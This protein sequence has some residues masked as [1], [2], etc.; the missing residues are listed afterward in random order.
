MTSIIRTFQ[1]VGLFA[2]SGY[3]SACTAC[4][5]QYDPKAVRNQLSAESQYANTTHPKLSDAGEL[6]SGDG[7]PVVSVDERYATLCSGCHGAGGGGDG[8]SG[9]AL[10]PKPRNFQL[11]SWQDSVDDARIYKVLKEGGASVGLS[12]MM[13]PW[14]SVLSDDEIK[15]MVTK[16]RSFRK[17]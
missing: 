2:V 7:A 12:A 16:V 17:Q 8:A 15:N 11:A 14:G 5:E 1:F 10:N 9:Q 13:A 6:P 4:L 3:L